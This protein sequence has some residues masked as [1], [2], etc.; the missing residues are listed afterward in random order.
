MRARMFLRDEKGAEA[1]EFGIVF[2]LVALILFALIYG[3]LALAAHLSLAHAAAQGVRFASIPVDPVAG[4]YPS[5]AA[6]E[7]RIDENTPFFDAAACETSVVGTAQ[8]N[9][10]LSLDVSCSF[11]N[12]LGAVLSALRELFSSSEGQVYADDLTI[13]AHTESRRE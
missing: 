12:P 13:T 5:V 1:L 6:V 4:T 11:P 7:E 2:P 3:L 9:V 10:P 8:E